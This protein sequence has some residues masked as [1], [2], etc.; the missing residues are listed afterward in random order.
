V[1]TVLYRLGSWTFD[2]RRTVVAIWVAVLVGLGVLAVALGGKVSNSFSVPGTESQ[3]ALNLLNKE[4]PGS[5]GATARIVFA[6]PPG[7]RLTEPRYRP[8]IRP[9]IRLAQHVPQSVGGA[10]A[11][12]QSFALSKDGRIGFANLQFSVPVDKLKSSTKAALARVA[13]PARTRSEAQRTPPAA[14]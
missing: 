12:R 10:A 1:A 9:T 8:L 14:R 6:A 4:F 13:A 2:H 3:R 7:H 11:F 5:G